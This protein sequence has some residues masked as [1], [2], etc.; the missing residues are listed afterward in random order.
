MLYPEIETVY[1]R[2]IHVTSPSILIETDTACMRWQPLRNS[3]ASR[4]EK[5]HK[6]IPTITIRYQL[7]TQESSFDAVIELMMTGSMKHM[8]NVRDIL[9]RCCLCIHSVSSCRPRPVCRWFHRSQFEHSRGTN[10]WWFEPHTNGSM[11]ILH[12]PDS[13]RRV[14]YGT[15]NRERWYSEVRLTCKDRVVELL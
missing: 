15:K 4:P 14:D 1:E 10:N 7:L 12:T 6:S 11:Y 3:W 8:A 9:C 13:H 2:P 5:F